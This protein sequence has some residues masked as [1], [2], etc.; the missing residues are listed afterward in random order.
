MSPGR[1]SQPRRRCAR[2]KSAAALLIAAWSTGACKGEPVPATA[3]SSSATPDVAPNGSLRTPQ[4]A[5]LKEEFVTVPGGTLRAGSRPG[6]P[7]RVPRLEPRTYEVEL[8]AFRMDKLPYP[9]DPSQPPLRGVSRDDAERRCAERGAR[10]CTE[11]EWERAC[12]G[13][14]NADFVTGS[15][16]TAACGTTPLRCASPFEVLGLT[17]LREWTASDLVVSG[18]ART[19]GAVVRGAS[20]TAPDDQ[21]R[22]AHRE[23]VPADRVSDDLGFRCCRGAPNA[24][25]VEEPK[26]GQTFVRRRLDAARLGRLLAADPRTATLAKD[27]KLFREPEAAR[28]VVARGPGDEKGFSFTVAPMV[29]NPSPGAEYLLVAARSQADTSFVLAYHVVGDDEFAL[30]ASFVMKGE[31]GPVAFAYSDYIR[32]RLH[33]ST[34]WGCPGET[35]KILFR[36]PDTVAILQP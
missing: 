5:P 27:V 12:K 13:P 8:G 31:P 35:G 4:Q 21:H 36:E 28:T 6:T 11:L 1:Q 29:W 23:I 16:W 26:L 20:A 9:N 25:K 3:T 19:S 32:P 18:D 34:C 17:T 2:S 30:A 24:A 33:F 15:A 7:G 14:E 22:C 10:L